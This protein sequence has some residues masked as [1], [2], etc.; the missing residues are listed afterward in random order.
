VVSCSVL[1][2]CP[3]LIDATSLVLEP[4]PVT[5]P[6]RLQPTSSPGL[7]LRLLGANQNCNPVPLAVR[8]S[9]AKSFC[10]NNRDQSGNGAS[11]VAV[12]QYLSYPEYTSK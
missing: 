5:C 10:N 1:A 2:I 12:V 3:R 9:Y 4:S 11:D 8:T 6:R 7:E